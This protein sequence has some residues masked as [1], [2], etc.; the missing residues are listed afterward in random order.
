[1]SNSH[2]TTRSFTVVIP[3]YNR[4]DSLYST[5][6]SLAQINY[7][8]HLWDIIVVD[9][10]SNEPLESI[11]K[12]AELPVPALCLRQRNAGPG[13]ARNTAAQASTMDYLAFT[14]DDCTPAPDWLL[15]LSRSFGHDGLERALVG[16]NIHHALPDRL[17][18]TASHLLVEHLK[19]HMNA[20]SARFF[21]PNNLAVHRES[22]LEAGGFH[23]S[24]GPTGEDREFCDR[25]AAQGRPIAFEPD[26]VVAHAHPQSLRGFLRQ[27]YSYGIGSAR[28]RALRTQP[29][30]PSIPEPLSFYVRLVLSPF[31][32]EFRNK[33]LLTVLLAASQVANTLGVIRERLFGKEKRG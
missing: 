2:D 15:A 6:H 3:C 23:A 9:D 4:P 30:T 31:R 5:L 22:F 10:G 7:P 27:H 29:N 18:P 1:M 33:A 28:F 12:N 21:T 8:A 17:C 25:W 16:G 14:A 32:S 19:S 13:A 11:V 20:K 24:F 26:A